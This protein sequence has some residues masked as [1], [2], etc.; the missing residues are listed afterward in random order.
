MKSRNKFNILLVSYFCPTRAHAGG[1]R[2]LD[3]YRLIK[4]KDPDIQIDIFTFHRPSIDWQIEDIYNIF[5]NVYL[6]DEEALSLDNLVILREELS[7]QYDIVDLQFHQSGFYIDEYRKIGKRILFTPMES[8]VKVFYLD[9]YRYLKNPVRFG[10]RELANSFARAFQ[11][12]NFCRKV[13]AV[14][15]VSKPDASFLKNFIPNKNIFAL[16]TGLSSLEF[17]NALQDNYIPLSAKNRDKTVLY[18]AYFGS[19]TNIDALKWFL[20]DVHPVI[21]SVVP[22][23]VLK[24]IGRGDLSLFQQCPYSNVEIIGPVNELES[25]IRSACIGIAPA[26]SGSGFRGK[27]NQY[28]IYGIPSVASNIAADGLVYQDRDSILIAKNSKQFAE[29]CIRLLVDD[30]LNDKIAESS[31]IICK[32]NYTWHSKWYQI[33]MIYSLPIIVLV[34]CQIKWVS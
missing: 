19:Q 20:K 24:V 21:S 16:E 33:K 3:I 13:D 26:L 22:E 12:I 14:V 15:C 18:V 4:Q 31:R 23:Y 29:N 6:S 2:I 30:N 10:L 17:S 7:L 9:I 25:F 32:S 5:D 8:L 1:L 27:I 11:E 28:A 34:L